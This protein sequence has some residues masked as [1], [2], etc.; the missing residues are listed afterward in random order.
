MLRSI[1]EYIVRVTDLLEAEGR[2]LRAGA[3]QVGVALALV[4]GAVALG[5]LAFA[6]VMFAIH[7]GLTPVIGQAWSAVIVAALCV[8]GAGGFAWAAKKTLD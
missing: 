8:L 2:R 1:S 5:V 4:L 7:T 3:M 6:L